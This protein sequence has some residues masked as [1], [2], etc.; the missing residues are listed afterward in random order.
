MSAVTSGLLR[1]HR[2]TT[3]VLQAGDPEAGEAVVF[4]HGTPG[5]AGEW[6]EQLQHVGAFTRGIALDM[7]GYGSA[8]TFPGFDHRVEGDYRTFLSEAFDT[9]ALSRVHLV[10]HDFGGPWGL[11]WAAA[12]P[13]RLASLTLINTGAMLDYSWHSYA[14]I[15][16]TPLLGEL[17]Q[18]VANRPGM[19]RQLRRSNP[20]L[21]AEFIDRMYDHYDAHTRR[22]VLA[23][24]RA[25]LDPDTMLAESAVTLPTDIPTL[26][27]WGDADPWVPARH[28]QDQPL[29]WPRAQVEMLEGLGHWPHA[30][31][32]D[33]VTRH[34]VPFL[35]ANV[36]ER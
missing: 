1:A 19:R 36:K 29:V 14:R 8:R 23:L 21:P 35:T 9:L 24:Y 28:A 11:A 13:D 20:R 31:A 7:P 15:W 18:A 16:Q 22:T 34:L 10:A 33:Q 12:H 25:A 17:V 27:L 5:C 26:V 30:D 2:V 4:L 3:T 32:P 6:L